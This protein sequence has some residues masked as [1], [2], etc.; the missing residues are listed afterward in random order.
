MITVYYPKNDERYIIKNGCTTEYTD[1]FI[2][3]F[4]KFNNLIASIC[5]EPGLI[6]TS[7][8]SDDIKIEDLFT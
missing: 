8:S 5:K 7:E 4:N 2:H 3:I 1:N 6:I